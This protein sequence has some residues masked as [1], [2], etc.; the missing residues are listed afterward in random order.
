F[1][2]GGMLWGARPGEATG[3]PFQI[4]SLSRGLGEGELLYSLETPEIAGVFALRDGGRDE[5][6]LFHGN[7]RRRV[8][9]LAVDGQRRLIACSV[10]HDAGTAAIAVMGADEL[11]LTEVTEGDSVDLAPSWVPGGRQI[12]FQSAGV[13]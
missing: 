8:R 2:S 11:D 5:Q 6:R 7:D 3:L 12:V 13:G 10:R 1:M 9:H 4:T